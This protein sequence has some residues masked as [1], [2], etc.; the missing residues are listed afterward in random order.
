MKNALRPLPVVPI[1]YMNLAGVGTGQVYTEG[2]V[3]HISKWSPSKLYGR[4]PV[5]TLWRQ[6]NALIAMDNYVYAAYQK[7][8]MPRGVMVIKSSNLET[9]EERHETYRNTLSVIRNTFRQS[10]LKPNR[11]V[12]VLNMSV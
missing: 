3:I 8:R 7:R 12:V 5:A 1:H 4:S 9:V 6:V 2:E 11:G 10:V